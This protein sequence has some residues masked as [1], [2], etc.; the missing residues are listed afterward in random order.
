MHA[1]TFCC[2]WSTV[3]TTTPFHS[4]GSTG[5]PAMLRGHQQSHSAPHNSLDSTAP[6][7]KRGKEREIPKVKRPTALKKVDSLRMKLS[8]SYFKY[9]LC[10]T[11]L[12]FVYVDYFE[13]TW[14][15]EREAICRTRVIK[16]WRAGG[17]VSSFY[18]W[19]YTRAC[20]PG[21]S[22]DFIAK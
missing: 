16:S 7:I 5:V 21:R 1:L 3:G 14:R 13:R 6:R 20:F 15:E 22:G 10:L 2:F 12:V 8:K 18:W 17:R 11:F 4:S 19:S 9:L